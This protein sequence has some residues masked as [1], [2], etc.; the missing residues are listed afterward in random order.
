MTE[1]RKS[2]TREP[3][4]QRREALIRATLAL[5]AEVGPAAA[6]VRAIAER[7]GISQG[8]IRHYFQTKEDLIG[9]AYEWHMRGLTGATD[10]A[11]GQAGGSACDRLARF[12][13]AALTPPVIDAQAM[14]LWAGFIHMVL[15]DPQMR[16]VHERTY[17]HFRDRLQDLIDAALREAGRPALPALARRHAIACNAVL[18]GLWLEGCALPEAFGPG[19]LTGIGLASVAAIL[20]LDLVA[21]GKP[22]TRARPA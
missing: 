4:E 12:V 9:A 3:A 5:M 17:R 21:G 13:T 10:T 11:A 19:E 14:S 1:T 2:F 20:E 15:R 7:A 6:T 16:A 18:D 22:S 8:M